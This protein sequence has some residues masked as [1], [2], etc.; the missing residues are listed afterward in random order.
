MKKK[1]LTRFKRWLSNDKQQKML[2]DDGQET[3]LMFKTIGDRYPY[4]GQ[5]MIRVIASFGRLVYETDLANVSANYL[6]KR[7][8]TFEW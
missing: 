8:Y 3:L 2:I 5:R 1:R 7:L 6:Y 4:Q